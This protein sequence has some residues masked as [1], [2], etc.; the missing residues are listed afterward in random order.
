MAHMDIPA[1]CSMATPNLHTIEDYLLLLLLEV[2]V[3]CVY[4]LKIFGQNVLEISTKIS[5]DLAVEILAQGTNCKGFN[6][7]YK[8]V[9]SKCNWYDLKKSNVDNGTP[10]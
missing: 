7:I 4:F 6:Y 10:H 8:R 9:I 3:I 1:N 5:Y 2:I